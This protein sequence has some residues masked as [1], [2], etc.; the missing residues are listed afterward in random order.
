RRGAPVSDELDVEAAAHEPDYQ[1]A[2]S[3]AGGAGGLPGSGLGGDASPGTLE[4]GGAPGLA[5]AHQLPVANPFHSD[6]VKSEVQLLRNRPASLDEDAA[7]LRGDVDE[8]L[9]EKVCQSFVVPWMGLLRYF[10]GLWEE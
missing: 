9:Q 2:L 5:T 7:R 8:D 4:S 10:L 3:Q 1:T 6:K